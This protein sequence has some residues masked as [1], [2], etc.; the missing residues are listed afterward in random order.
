MCRPVLTHA[1][2]SY[3]PPLRQHRA[4]KLKMLNS[5]TPVLCS[6]AV[7]KEVFFLFNILLFCGQR[8]N[9][10]YETMPSADAFLCSCNS[11]ATKS[12]MPMRK[13]AY[14]ING[15]ASSNIFWL[16]TGEASLKKRSH[17]SFGS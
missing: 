14:L 16:R 3:T 17:D 12:E 11:L 5:T 13:G 15:E 7:I 1:S 8:N 9:E 2:G 6:K 10:E 4:L